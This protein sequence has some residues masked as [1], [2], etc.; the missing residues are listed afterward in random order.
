M[1][2]LWQSPDRRVRASVEVEG[3]VTRLVIEVRELR[4]AERRSAAETLAG[5]AAGL[6][7]RFGPVRDGR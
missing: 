6:W 1:E 3:R 4:A 7:A 2:Q 5:V